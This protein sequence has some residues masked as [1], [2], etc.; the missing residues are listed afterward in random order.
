MK[1]LERLPR[2]SGGDYALR[3]IKENIINLELPP[4]SQISENELAAEM[5]ET[6]DERRSPLQKLRDIFE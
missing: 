5:G 2:E 1:L 3:T 6:V 4:G